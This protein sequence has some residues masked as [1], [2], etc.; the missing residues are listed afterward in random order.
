VDPNN[1]STSSVS[2][3]PDVEAE[4]ATLK[5][6]YS[7]AQVSIET[8]A[9]QLEET[10]VTMHLDREFLLMDEKAG[11]NAELEILKGAEKVNY[12]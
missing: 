3:N 9:F 7:A 5:I 10:N 4:L 11:L 2:V 12:I 1:S 8:L 6:K